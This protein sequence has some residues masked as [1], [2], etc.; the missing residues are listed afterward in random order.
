MQVAE[1]E[2][3]GKD[4]SLLRLVGNSLFAIDVNFDEE[5]YQSWWHSVYNN[6][7]SFLNAEIRK[8]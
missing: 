1:W 2:D 4:K 7:Q 6:K 8:W 3:K 5:C